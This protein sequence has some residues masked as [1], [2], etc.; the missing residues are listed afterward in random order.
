[1]V[2]SGKKIRPFSN[3]GNQNIFLEKK[4]TPP[5]QVKWSFPKYPSFKLLIK[6]CSKKSK[7]VL[8]ALISN[9]E[10]MLAGPG[11]ESILNLDTAK[12][13]ENLITITHHHID[14]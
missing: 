10:N 13:Q 14:L 11:A 7:T 1:M 9:L 6:I 3:I 8:S 5:F 12:K 2:N 4:H